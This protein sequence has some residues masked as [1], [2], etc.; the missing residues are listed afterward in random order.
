MHGLW[1]R[2]WKEMAQQIK[3]TG[4]NAVRVPFCPA[5]LTNKA[6]SSINYGLNP[7]LVGLNSLDILDLVMGELDRLGIYILLDHHTS[8]CQTIDELWYTASYSEQDWIEDLVFVAD[9]YKDNDHL[10]GIDLKNEPHGPATW[11]TGDTATDWKIAAEKAADE[12][13]FVN[14]NILVFVQGVQNNP[15]MQREYKPLVGR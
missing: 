5:T 15:Y 2:N 12:V 4:F 14:Q 13:L 1:A 7:D 10:V 8:D 6:T 3:D 11:G 9:R